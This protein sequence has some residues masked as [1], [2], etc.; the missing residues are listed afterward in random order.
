MITKRTVQ[1]EIAF[2][3]TGA[4]VKRANNVIEGGILEPKLPTSLQFRMWPEELDESGVRNPPLDATTVDGAFQIS[5]SGTA[6][7]YRELGRY[8]IALAEL[9]THADPQFHEHHEMTSGDGR[10]HLHVIVRKQPE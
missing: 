5:L 7:A 9:D 6:A 2:W 1:V 10:T 4:I 8:F 3:G